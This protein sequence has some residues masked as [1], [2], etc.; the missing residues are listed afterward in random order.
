MVKLGDDILHNLE[1][2]VVQ[3]KIILHSIKFEQTKN[4]KKELDQ[5]FKNLGNVPISIETIESFTD[6]LTKP[7]INWKARKEYNEI[8]NPPPF[9]IREGKE[10]IGKK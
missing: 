3:S 6:P 7:T 4:E 2:K 1:Q 10:K 8:Q 9:T 5:P